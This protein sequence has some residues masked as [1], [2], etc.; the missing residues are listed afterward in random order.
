MKIGNKNIGL[1]YPPFVIA[2]MSGN[3]NQSI[4]TAL[5]IVKAAA[6]AGAHALKLQTYTTNYY[7]KCITRRIF[8]RDKKSIWNG[9][10]IT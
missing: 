7:I 10:K 5:N 2:E 3:H 8:I 9:K 1:D 6:D 4:E